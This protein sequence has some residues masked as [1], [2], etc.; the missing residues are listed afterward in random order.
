MNKAQQT[1][2]LDWCFAIMEIRLV[3]TMKGGLQISIGFALIALFL[4]TMNLLQAVLASL[5]IGLIIINVMA[6]VAYME[7]E[8]GSGESVGVVVCVGFA[9]DYVVHLASHY[10]HS[11]HHSRYD[12]IRESLRELGG[13]ILSGSITTSG[14]ACNSSSYNVYVMYSVFCD[15]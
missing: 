4:A 11:K 13:S 9:V 3:E 6:I 7:W 8:L 10:I 15:V 5:T 2:G 14:G 1:A 12:R